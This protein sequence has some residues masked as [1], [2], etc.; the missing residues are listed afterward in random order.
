MEKQT[1]KKVLNVCIE[2][3]K[4][5][6]DY[7]PSR[8]IYKDKPCKYHKRKLINQKYEVKRKIK[9]KEIRKEKEANKYF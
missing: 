5:S 2:C 1:Q 6:L 3:A 7:A 4:G 8:F 9:R